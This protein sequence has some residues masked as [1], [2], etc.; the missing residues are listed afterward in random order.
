MLYARVHFSFLKLRPRAAHQ[1]DA[2]P[3]DVGWVLPVL[4]THVN[5]GKWRAVVSLPFQVTMDVTQCAQIAE[6][7]SGRF[8]TIFSDPCCGWCVML[9]YEYDSGIIIYIWKNIY[10]IYLVIRIIMYCDVMILYDMREDN[11]YCV[12]AYVLSSEWVKSV[13][14][15]RFQRILMLPLYVAGNY[16]LY[17]IES[18]NTN[19]NE[20]RSMYVLDCFID[21]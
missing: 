17:L 12:R 10:F 7:S 8:G 3:S 19:G 21:I 16:F 15:K 2:V 5:V 11:L 6:A 14:C 9:P 1:D 18:G 4:T 13:P 20:S